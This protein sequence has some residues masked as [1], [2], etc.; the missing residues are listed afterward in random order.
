L[1]LTPEANSGNGPV[2]FKISQGYQSKIIV[3]LKL[4]TNTSLVHGYERQLEIYKKADDSNQGIFVLVD[5]GYL[6]QKL[7]KIEK[8]RES[9][10]YSH[11]NA[12]EIFY[13]DVLRKKSASKR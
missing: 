8:S 7:M 4:S 2:D 11:D 1:A 5:V 13:V 10:L 6:G 3:E 12:S 9:F